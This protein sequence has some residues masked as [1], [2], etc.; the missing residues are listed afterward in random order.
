VIK[1]STYK[2]VSDFGRLRSYVYILV[3]MYVYIYI[4]IYIHV[5]PINAWIM[6]HIKLPMFS[7]SVMSSCS[8]CKQSKKSKLLNP[9]DG[10]TLPLRIFGS[11]L[12]FHMT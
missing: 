11:C 4:Y 8:G 12:Q 2:H 1:K 6:D 9:E 7:N 3:C 5:Y 10:D